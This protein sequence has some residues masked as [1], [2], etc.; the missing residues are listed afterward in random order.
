MLNVCKVKGSEHDFARTHQEHYEVVVGVFF[1][2]LGM[3]VR[4][5]P[6]KIGCNKLLVF[7]KGRVNF[8]SITVDERLVL[9]KVFSGSKKV[10][11]RV[12]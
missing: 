1:V 6:N 9:Y 2:I 7:S 12:L 4:G 11:D 8:I 10:L 5:K 3:T